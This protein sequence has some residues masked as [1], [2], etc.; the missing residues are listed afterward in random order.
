[1]QLV[2]IAVAG[3]AGAVARYR[4]GVAIGVRSFPWATLAVNVLGTFVLAVVLTGPGPQRWS[5]T[6]TSAVAVGLIGSFTTFSTFGWE[7]F[8]LLRT[9]R[10]G[11]AFAYVAASLLGGL[12]AAAAGYSLG[13][14][15]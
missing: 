11:E 2:W 10:A 9:D 15:S 4:I 13:Q 1:M 7:T 5:P 8:T 14:R 3:A 6:V 12:A